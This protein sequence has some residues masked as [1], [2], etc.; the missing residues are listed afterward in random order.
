MPRCSYSTLY[1]RYNLTRHS[2]GKT[3]EEAV[4]QILQIHAILPG[5]KPEKQ[6]NIPS[7]TSSIHRTQTNE[8]TRPIQQVQPAQPQSTTVQSE[9]AEIAQHQQ[10]IVG[11]PSNFDGTTAHA[12][13]QIHSSN[14]TD[15][16]NPQPSPPEKPASQPDAVSSEN[17]PKFADELPPSRLLHSNPVKE[18]HKDDLL[19][20]TDSQTLEEEEFHDAQS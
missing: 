14:P 1:A 7:R 17:P 5:Q 13:P 2:D 16:S 12:P 4:K 19:R 11:P 3:P 15:P 20:R 8:S 18:A 6:F 10:Q 9:P